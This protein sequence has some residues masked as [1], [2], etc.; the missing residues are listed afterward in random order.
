VAGTVTQLTQPGPPTF[1]LAGAGSAT[2][3]GAA[4]YSGTV[5]VTSAPGV[6][7]LTDD[8]SETLT[9]SNGDTLTLL[10]HQTA[11]PIGSTGVLHGT[12][13]WTVTGGTGRFAHASGSGTGDTYIYNLALFTKSATGTINV[14]S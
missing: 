13:Q 6:V 12:D 1:A 4:S 7:P 14:G 8:L 9:A 5:T 10:C 3:L 11:T 2:G